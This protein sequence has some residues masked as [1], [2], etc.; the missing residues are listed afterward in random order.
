MSKKHA[1]QDYYKVSGR[2]EKGR[3]PSDPDVTNEKLPR[4]RARIAR[5]EAAPP[6]PNP[7]NPD[8]REALN[9]PD[10]EQ[11]ESA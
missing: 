11:R 1:N 9:R 6:H 5:G 7:N 10:E 2:D 8:D 4:S 3:L